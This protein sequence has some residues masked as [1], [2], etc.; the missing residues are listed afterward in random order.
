LEFA[1]SVEKVVLVDGAKLTE[2]L[3]EHGVGVTHR[4]IKI[5]KIDNDYFEE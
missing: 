2:L 3:M 5:P 4:A 1:R